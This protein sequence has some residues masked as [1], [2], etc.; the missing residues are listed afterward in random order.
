MGHGVAAPSVC[1]ASPLSAT[2]TVSEVLPVKM[3]RSP[4]SRTRNPSEIISPD[5]PRPAAGGG[6]LDSE[7]PL[8]PGGVDLEQIER[9][10]V[11]RALRDA[12]GNKSKAA[13][14]LGLSRAQLYSRLE[15]YGIT[16]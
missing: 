8:P 10:L 1:A 16:P 14:L 3:T 2:V 11:E 9:N 15:K 12:K 6:A 7:A 5:G 13:R 4:S